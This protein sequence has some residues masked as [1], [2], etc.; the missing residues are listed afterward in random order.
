MNQYILEYIWI[1]DNKLLSETRIIK[2]NNNIPE[3]YN[4]K[5]IMKP[6]FICKNYLKKID[7]SFLV[8]C[9]VYDL[10]N[11]PLITNNRNKSN[12]FHLINYDKMQDDNESY[13][14]F[15]QNYQF[16]TSNLINNQKI[17]DEHLQACLYAD[18]NI[19]KINIGV[20]EIGPCR[21]DQL[22]IARFLLEKISEKYNITILYNNFSLC[23]STKETRNPDGIYTIINYINNLELQNPENNFSYKIPIYTLKNNSGYFEIL[24]L[25]ENDP[26]LI[27]AIIY[28]SCCL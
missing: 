18:L 9:D 10:N 15:T 16:I 7:N 20:F 12:I 28:I 6:C 5:N 8:L 1:D 27:T 13:F 22:Y 11:N 2:T 4:Y 24:Q 23:F 3:I 21:G 17:I 25:K 14:I 19:S 26:Y